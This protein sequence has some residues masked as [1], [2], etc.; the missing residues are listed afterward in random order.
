MGITL[1]QADMCAS[2]IQTI[3][4]SASAELNSTLLTKKLM[5]AVSVP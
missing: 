5:W 2:G 1:A 4:L 3:M